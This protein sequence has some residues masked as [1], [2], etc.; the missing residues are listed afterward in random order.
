MSHVVGKVP[1]GWGHVFAPHEILGGLRTGCEAITLGPL[2]D[3]GELVH[4]VLSLP[5]FL[6]SAVL[7]QTV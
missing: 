6:E 4:L 1:K 2:K 7:D 5:R 3:R